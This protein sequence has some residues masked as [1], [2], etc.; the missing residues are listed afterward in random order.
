VTHH[1]EGAMSPNMVGSDQVRYFE[2]SPDGKSLYLSVKSGDRVT[3]SSNGIATE[4]VYGNVN[5][6]NSAG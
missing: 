1:V 5:A 3:G 2:F 6:T 4:R